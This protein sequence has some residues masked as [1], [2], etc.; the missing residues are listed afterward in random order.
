MEYAFLLY[1][2]ANARYRASLKTLAEAELALLLRALGLQASATWRTLGGGDW[3]CFEA[4]D[5]ARDAW[6]LLCRHSAAYV[7]AIRQGDALCPLDADRPA[8]VGEDLAALLKY[9]GKTNEMFTE[10]LINAA[11]ASG[12]F[13]LQGD[14]PLRLLDPLCGRGTSLFLALRRG[15]HSAGIERD[16]ADVREL[17]QFL[18]RYLTYHHMK[19]KKEENTLTVAGRLGARQW[20]YDL[21]DTPQH[22]K[23]GDTRSLCVALGDTRDAAALW[24]AAHF[25]LLAADLP[26]GVQHAAQNGGKPQSL[27]TL[28]RDALP[29]WREALLPGG[30]A[31][32]A[33][34]TYTTKREDL[35][36]WMEQAG[37]AVCRGGPYEAMAHWVE[38]AV[39]RDVLV[40]VRA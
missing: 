22:Y 8:Y 29:A 17:N 37:F 40:G 31:A 20:R 35:A 7:L 23:A 13:A 9:K 1:P 21:A 38:Q 4:D 26:Y 10:L 16:K 6:R 5:F 39:N 28:L 3:L 36:A 30:A 11:L 27:Q 19:H 25:H 2:H 12:A 33:F 14:E 34:N 24:G 18:A 15:W 32:L